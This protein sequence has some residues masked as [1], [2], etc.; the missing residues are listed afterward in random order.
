MSRV[1][2]WMPNDDLTDVSVTRP[3][4]TGSATGRHLTDDEVAE[5]AEREKRRVPLGFVAPPVKPKRGKRA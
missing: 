5:L 1:R 2:H 3:S 4:G